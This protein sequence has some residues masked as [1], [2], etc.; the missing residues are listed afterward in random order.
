MLQVLIGTEIHSYQY[1][2][3]LSYN[4]VWLLGCYSC[5]M[6]WGG[7]ACLS[8]S[9][10]GLQLVWIQFSFSNISC[11][12]KVKELSL[13]YL[14]ITEGR[15]VGFISFP[16]V[17]ATCEMQKISFRIWTLVA[18]STTT[19]ITV[20]LWALSPLTIYTQKS[21]YK[22]L[23]INW[24]WYKILMTKE[25]KYYYNSSISNVLKIMIDF[26]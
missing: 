7:I 9:S 22:Q 10:S 15:I 5:H 16:R 20:T 6:S 3:D 14:P 19:T 13:S 24:N 4:L 11:H 21:T 1:R 8:H 18:K 23:I 2:K 17:L 25:K 12:T 26:L